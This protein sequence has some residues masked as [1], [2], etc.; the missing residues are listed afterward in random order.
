[1]TSTLRSILIAGAAIAAL[2]TV[3][4]CNK[5]AA[6]DA[7]NAAASDANAAMAS[8]NSA[9]NSAMAANSAAADTSANAMATPPATNGQ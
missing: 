8:A 9:S 5:P 4:A 3:A 1:M 6:N 7:A 2:S